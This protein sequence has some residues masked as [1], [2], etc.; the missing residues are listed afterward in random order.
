M[1]IKRVGLIALLLLLAARVFADDGF[2]EIGVNAKTKTSVLLSSKG[3]TFSLEDAMERAKIKAADF[4]D[5][6]FYAKIYPNATELIKTEDFKD[7]YIYGT[8]TMAVVNLHYGAVQIDYYRWDNE[9][10]SIVGWDFLA[11][12][13]L[14]DGRVLCVKILNNE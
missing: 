4:G 9:M 7:E 5:A 1:K 3:K 2:L 14:D 8:A 11:F 10:E 13:A 12:F 6:G